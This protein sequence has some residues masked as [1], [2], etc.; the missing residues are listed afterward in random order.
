MGLFCDLLSSDDLLFVLHADFFALDLSADG[1]GKLV[2]KFY[3]SGVFVRCGD[4]FYMV[5]KLFYKL[6]TGAEAACE[7]DGRLDHLTSDG[8]GSGSDSAFQYGRVS[9]QCALYLKGPY[10][11]ARALDNV[12]VTSF[13]VEISIR[14][15]P[16]NVARVVNAVNPYSVHGVGIVDILSEKSCRMQ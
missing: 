10:A 9:E 14:I 6:V 7:H 13:K 1:F 5:L 16:C 4:L 11:V 15:A 2:H 12:I 3:Y 8:I